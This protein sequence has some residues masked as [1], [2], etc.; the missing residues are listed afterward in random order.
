MWNVTNPVGSTATALPILG[1][2]Q[3]ASVAYGPNGYTL[4][5]GTQDGT[6]QLWN[7]DVEQA[8]D[9]ICA[10]SGNLT[11]QQRAACIS[12]Q[13]PYEPPCAPA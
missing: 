10:T 5:V 3:L 12:P 6:V 7:L 2:S 4:A 13:L 11:W 1:P 9:R 8:I